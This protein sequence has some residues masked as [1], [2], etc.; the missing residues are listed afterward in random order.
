[1]LLCTL[2][3]PHLLQVILG[4][5]IYDPIL[6]RGVRKKYLHDPNPTKVEL[7]RESSYEEVLNMAVSLYFEAYDPSLDKLSLADS[8][9]MPI[10]VAS[11]DEW[12]LGAFYQN[13][14]L[15]PSRYKLY[16]VL[17]VIDASVHCVFAGM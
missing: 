8:N 3:P 9:G 12:T 2:T 16:V 15:Q 6:C 13:N 1:M 11:A 10:Q 4:G 5:M 14:G 7:K 17:Q